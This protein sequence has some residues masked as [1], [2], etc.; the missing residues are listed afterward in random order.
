MQ[1]WKAAPALACI[2][3]L[4]WAGPAA[5]ELT[6]AGVWGSLKGMAESY[7]QQ[8]TAT[9]TVEGDSLVVRDVSVTI[10]TSPIELPEGGSQSSTASG[11]IAEI[12][13]TET[14]DGAVRITMAPEGVLAV[15]SEARMNGETAR[16]DVTMRMRQT[17]LE[18]V[19]T[20]SPG[21][22][23]Y[24]FTA[25]EV[26]MTMDQM[27][28]DGET[29]PAQ[30]QMTA[31]G[32]SGMY[33]ITGTDSRTILSDFAADSAGFD[34]DLSDPAAG[35][36]VKIVATVGALTSASRSVLP[37]QM[38]GTDMAR[39]LKAGFSSEGNIAY[40]PLQMTADVTEAGAPT[41]MA[42]A[43]TGGRFDFA[44]DSDQIVYRTA[45][46]GTEMMVSGAQ[47]PFPQLAMQIEEGAFGLT[48]PT[49][50]GEEPGD[51]G[52]LTRLQGLTVDEALWSMIDPAGAL[53]RDPAT[54][55][56]DL[57]GKARMLADLFDPMAIAEL[58]GQPPAELQ[59][60]DVNALQL[61]VAGADLSGAGAFSFDNSDTTPFNGMPK[62]TGG[63]S[64][65][66]T[67]A[68][69]LLDKLVAMGLVPQ[70]QATGFR[71]MLGM[72]AK[73]GEGADTLVSDIQVTEDGQILANGQ[74][75]R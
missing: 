22:I 4:A 28:V 19:A 65:R 66:L 9:E 54:L 27:T 52:L 11:A 24:R 48:M 56:I 29:A 61:S 74:R 26:G 75:L 45:Q 1:H 21:D 69:A 17:G 59:S 18:A 72:F 20:G 8:I 38:D 49:A 34:F 33:R 37:P 2:A 47:I 64:L 46:S 16:S 6:A 44:L 15:N 43:S 36:A 50:Q 7:G 31:G 53:P 51:F 41:R 73:P 55:V 32:V 13:F 67:G 23:T 30:M 10:E 3:G 57:S 60:L 68:N 70:D 5:A 35:T 25:P 40:G 63:L 42:M 62:P 58:Q 12:V 14:G 39:M 71:M